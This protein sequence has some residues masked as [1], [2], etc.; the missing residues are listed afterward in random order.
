MIK[1]VKMESLGNRVKYLHCSHDSEASSRNQA[2]RNSD[3]TR[4]SLT[5]FLDRKLHNS[6][7]VPQTVPGKLTPFQSPASEQ[8][9]SVKL[10]EEERKSATADEKLILGMFKQE[11]K[12]DFVPPL[13]L[14]ELGNSVA[15]DGQGARKRKNPF[16]VYF[17]W[18]GHEKRFYT[19]NHFN[20]ILEDQVGTMSLISYYVCRS[21]S[22]ASL[23]N[24]NR[25]FILPVEARDWIE[26]TFRE[27][28]RRYKHKIK[29]NHFLKYS[30][31]T[32]RL[33]NHP[34]NVPIAQFKSL[35][36]YWSKETIQAISENNTR[37]RAQLKWMHQM[38][39]KN[40]AL[41]REKVR[42][43]KKREPTQSE[44]FVETRKGNKGKEL[45]VETGKVISQLQEMRKAEINALKQAHSEEVS[46]LR[47]EFQDKIDRLQNAFKT[48][49][50]QCNPQ[51][52]IES[53]K[54]LLGLSHGDPNSSP[55]DIRPQMH[56]STST[57]APCHGKQCINE[58]VEKDDI[59]DEIQEDDINDKI[60]EDD[61]NDK[62]QEDDV[63]DE[64]QEDNIDLDDEFQ[65]EDID[66]EFQEDDVDEEFMED[67]ISNE[68]QEDDLDA[69]LLE[70]KLE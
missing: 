30:N 38:G 4:L 35:C 17:T 69:L 28:W 51:I 29:K 10:T 26:T 65:E 54:D 47:D 1:K 8:D 16:E 32:E 11:G 6:S 49:M 22:Y 3:S 53:I 46:T 44:M 14:D 59:N 66:G 27:A 56:S 15:G 21:L 67:D 34:P 63:D 61:L 19:D 37:N 70:D 5:H 2:S 31:M 20:S 39:P 36:A 41:T 68:F 12:C 25:K 42:E 45:D 52:N 64:F 50:Q 9:G 43:K 18:N 57:H 33:K 55:K 40:F 48:V 24:F 62:I 13:D 60:Q 7:T 23:G 58:D